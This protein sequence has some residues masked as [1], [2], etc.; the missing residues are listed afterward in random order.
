[1]RDYCDITLLNLATRPIAVPSPEDKQAFTNDRHSLHGPKLADLRL[2]LDTTQWQSSVWNKAASHLVANEFIKEDEYEC[3]NVKL[4]RKAFMSHL[5]QLRNRFVTQ[6][7]A[8][9]PPDDAVELELVQAAKHLRRE[10]RR[11]AVSL[12]TFP[13]CVLC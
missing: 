4:V 7:R 2:D 5:A 10:N 9:L 12:F 11:R 6:L 1:M 3:K 13:V 8:Q